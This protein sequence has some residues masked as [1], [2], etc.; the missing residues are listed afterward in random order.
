MAQFKKT[1]VNFM[2]STKRALKDAASH[3][4]LWSDKIVIVISSCK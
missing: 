2:T 1:D 3:L 4:A